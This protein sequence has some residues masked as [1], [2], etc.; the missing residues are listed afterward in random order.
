MATPKP[1]ARNVADLKSSILNPSLTSTYECHF[2]P[3]PS[4]KS[5]MN[6]SSLG[7]GYNFNKDEKL[8]IS[9]R[10]A[11]LPGTSLATHTLDNDHTGVTERHVYRRQYDTTASFTFYVDD[12]YDNIYFFENWIRFIVNEPIDDR[13]NFNYRVNFPSE[14]KTKIFIRKFEKDYKGRNLEY[15]F[16]DAYPVS[17]NQMPVNYDASQIL[18]CTVN[19]NFSRYILNNTSNQPNV[20]DYSSSFK[21]LSE[22]PGFPVGYTEVNRSFINNNTQERSTWITPNGETITTIDRVPQ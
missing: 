4:V 3:P 2:N 18:Q 1:R 13:P 21:S 5:W 10:E 20:F 14:Y 7:G 12:V 11:S 15:T 19:F 22:L 9:C 6:R 16:M 17:I 8:T